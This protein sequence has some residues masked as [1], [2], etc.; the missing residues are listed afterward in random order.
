MNANKKTVT[1]TP[2]TTVDDNVVSQWMKDRVG[3]STVR[4]IAMTVVT[5][6]CVRKGFSIPSKYFLQRTQR[7]ERHS[8]LFRRNGIES[9]WF[10][11]PVQKMFN[12]LR[13]DSGLLILLIRWLLLKTNE[14]LRFV[15]PLMMVRLQWGFRS[16]IVWLHSKWLWPCHFLSWYR[17]LM[18]NTVV[19][20][21]TKSIVR[22]SDPDTRSLSYGDFT[23]DT[24][25]SMS[26]STKAITLGL[27][28]YMY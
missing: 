2:N 15:N 27:Y 14:E 24:L 12:G 8:R 19:A 16:S 11:S 23:L 22:C 21:K 17:K 10:L 3:K 1:I 13:A 18:E 26:A 6:M 28:V 5:R 9:I 7:S 25:V 4:P 20:K